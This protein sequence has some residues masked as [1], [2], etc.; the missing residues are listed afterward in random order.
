MGR[1]KLPAD[2]EHVDHLEHTAEEE[3]AAGFMEGPFEAEDQV[4]AYFGHSR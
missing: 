3:L 2:A 4:T 1:V